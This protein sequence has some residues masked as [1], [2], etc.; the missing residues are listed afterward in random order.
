MPV[1]S[2][3]SAPYSPAAFLMEWQSVNQ[4]LMF[5]ADLSPGLETIFM[6]SF[7]KH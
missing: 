7:I 5:N 3:M 4:D 2:L 1:M 6:T